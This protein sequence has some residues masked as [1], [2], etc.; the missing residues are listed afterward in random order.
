[1]DQNNTTPNDNLSQVTTP[2]SPNKSFI[3]LLII[4]TIAVLGMAVYFR[5]GQTNLNSVNQQTDKALSESEKKVEELDN[6]EIKQNLDEVTETSQDS[7]NPTENKEN[8]NDL[9]AEIESLNNLKFDIDDSSLNE[10]SLNDLT[11]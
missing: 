10:S 1:M 5:Y 6:N 9:D 2:K 7:T 11:N 4:L 8:K 3:V